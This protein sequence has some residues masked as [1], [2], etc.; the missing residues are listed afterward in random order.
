MEMSAKHFIALPQIV[1][2]Q[3]SKIDGFKYSTIKPRIN[4]SF[5][6]NTGILLHSFIKKQGRLIK[7]SLNACRVIKLHISG[8]F[9]KVNSGC[10]TIGKICHKILE[11]L[12]CGRIKLS[13]K[14]IWKMAKDTSKDQSGYGALLTSQC[15]FS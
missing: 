5:Y 13:S 7:R 6:R 15:T 10:S 9:E 12:Q 8:N 14:M 11:V 1:F 2:A 3:F 4:N